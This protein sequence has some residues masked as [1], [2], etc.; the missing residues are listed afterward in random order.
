MEALD[1]MEIN[2]MA[3]NLI[4]QDILDAFEDLDAQMDGNLSGRIAL[5]MR[6]IHP[7][8]FTVD[9]SV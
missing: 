9:F 4:A 7:G 2:L 8:I 6:R 3:N 5:R 1:E